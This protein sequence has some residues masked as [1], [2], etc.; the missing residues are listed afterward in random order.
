MVFNFSK[1]LINTFIGT[2]SGTT[3]VPTVTDNLFSQKTIPT[4]SLAIS[5]NPT[6]SS[7]EVNGELTF[8]STDSSRYAI[9]L[10][11]H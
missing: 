5:F 10:S 3:S 11:L 8:G 9:S 4:E 6:T 2:V 7:G 1:H